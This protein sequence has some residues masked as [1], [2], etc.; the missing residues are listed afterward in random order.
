MI[1]M[2]IFDLDGTLCPLAQP[3]KES[4]VQ[5]LKR[6]MNDGIKVV[7]CSGKPTYYLCGQARQMGLR[8]AILAGENGAMIQYGVDLPPRDVKLP[9]PERDREELRK[10]KESFY[11]EFGD[12]Y[13]TQPNVVMFTPFFKDEEGHA[14]LREFFDRELDLVNTSLQCFDQVDCFDI[15]PN[16]N[17]ADAVKYLMEEFGLSEE[18]IVAVGDGVNDLPMF[19]KAGHTIGIGEKLREYVDH[20]VKDIDGALELI[21]SMLQ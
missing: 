16:I 8:E 1:K 13:W 4:T 21:D 12:R 6:Y 18:E 15:T 10:V 5:A 7:I 2:L 19:E 11:R 9:I 20:T 3:A 17:K 14:E